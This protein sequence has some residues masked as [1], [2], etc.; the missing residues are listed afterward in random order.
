[1]PNTHLTGVNKSLAKLL[2]MIG[3]CFSFDIGQLIYDQIV[4]NVEVLFTHQ[5]LP[6]PSLIYGVLMSQNDIKKPVEVFAKLPGELRILKKLHFG[7][8]VDDVQGES[9]SDSEDELQEDV[10]PHV[11][12]G[13]TSTYSQPAAVV[14]KSQTIQY[15]QKEL[16]VLAA[17]EKRLLQ[18]LKEI[19]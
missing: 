2:Y 14:Q 13:V 15:L 6:F 4:S 1:M 9:F 5:V 17:H 8:H 18:E 11:S 3:L 7:K 10:T 12:I 19:D 16:Q